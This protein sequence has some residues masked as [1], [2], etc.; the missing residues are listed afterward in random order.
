MNAA[1][2]LGRL[3]IMLPIHV[4]LTIRPTLTAT[5]TRAASLRLQSTR[6]A[7]CPPNMTA[8]FQKPPVFCC[9]LCCRRVFRQ[10]CANCH[11]ESNWAIVK[12]HRSYQRRAKKCRICTQGEWMNNTENARRKMM[13][14]MMMM[15]M[16]MVMVLSWPRTWTWAPSCPFSFPHNA[17]CA[18]IL[19]RVMFNW[20]RFHYAARLSS[21]CFPAAQAEELLEAGPAEIEAILWFIDFARLLRAPC[22]GQSQAESSGGLLILDFQWVFVW[23][24]FD[25][26]IKCTHART[27]TRSR[28][29]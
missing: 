6:A 10:E 21:H 23:W 18:L 16:V 13:T 3:Q 29:P 4:R 25:Q 26:L 8:L 19:A 7:D 28:T 27:H 9:L 20:M 22:S 15:V 1:G 17:W 11:I 24:R 5:H 14:L 2:S 12:Y